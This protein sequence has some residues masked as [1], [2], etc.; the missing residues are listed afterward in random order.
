MNVVGL[1]AAINVLHA[2]PTDQLTRERP[3]GNDLLDASG[4]AAGS[5][6]LTLVP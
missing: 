3:G 2:E 6:S 5:I 4:L 1:A